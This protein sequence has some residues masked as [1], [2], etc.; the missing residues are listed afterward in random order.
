MSLTN[1]LQEKITVNIENV[2]ATSSLHHTVNIKKILEQFPD[3]KYSPDKFPGAVVRMSKP[4][5]VIL[6]FK[7]GSI[8]STGTNSEESAHEAISRF[9]MKIK[10]VEKLQDLKTDDIKIENV[11]ASCNLGRKIHLEQ[12]ARTLPRSMYEPEQFPAVIHRLYYP[13]TVALIFA[14]GRIVCV[15]GKSSQEV[16]NSINTIRMELEEHDLIL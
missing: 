8:V 6:V 1:I 12:A 14:S 2:V 10:N 15:G 7:S 5:S 16:K 4:R 13:K 3:S 9:A 11:V